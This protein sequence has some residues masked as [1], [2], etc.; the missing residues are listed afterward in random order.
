MVDAQ[1]S[2]CVYLQISYSQILRFI[3][4]FPREMSNLVHPH[5]LLWGKPMGTNAQPQVLKLRR[6]HAICEVKPGSRANEPC[7]FI[8]KHENDMPCTK[9]EACKQHQTVVAWLT[10]FTYVWCN[11]WL[12]HGGRLLPTFGSRETPKSY[13]L[14]M[15]SGHTISSLVRIL[16]VSSLGNLH[17]Q[18]K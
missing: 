10:Y 8:K 11:G 5:P 7:D 6:I 12:L 17:T 16:A 18:P 9:N 13:R 14:A 3:I 1:F 15:T 4:K 2:T